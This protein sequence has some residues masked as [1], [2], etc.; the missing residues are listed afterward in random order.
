[1]VGRK[2]FGRTQQKSDKDLRKETIITV[3]KR[4]TKFRCWALVCAFQFLFYK[5]TNIGS[6]EV[7]NCNFFIYCCSWL[8]WVKKTFYFVLF[9]Y[10]WRTM[11]YQMFILHF[12]LSPPSLIFF[13]W[14]L[15]VCG[16]CIYA[17]FRRRRKGIWKN[18]VDALPPSP[19]YTS[20]YIRNHLSIRVQVCYLFTNLYLLRLSFGP[21]ITVLLI[22]YFRYI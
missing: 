20:P 5:M 22:M 1:M 21:C 6:W 13:D 4:V 9:P 17:A 19:T 14:Y 8:M 7:S 2:E 3:I 16:Y 10:L 11:S 12:C 15:T 18:D